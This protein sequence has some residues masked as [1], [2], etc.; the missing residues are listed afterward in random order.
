MRN[1]DFK[2]VRLA[3]LH[4]AETNTAGQSLLAAQATGLCSTTTH[5]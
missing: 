5:D 3:E 1:I 4:S 2:S